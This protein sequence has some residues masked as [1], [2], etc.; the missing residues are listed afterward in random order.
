MSKKIISRVMCMILAVMMIL[1]ACSV[2]ESYAAGFLKAYTISSSN[3][4]VY[5][6][7]Y[8]QTKYGTIYPTDEL[9]ISEITASYLKVTYPAGTKTKTGY[10]PTNKV[11]LATSGYA[12]KVT[13]KITTY[14]RNSTGKTYGYIS[15]GDSVIELGTRGD[16][17]QVYYPVSGGNKIGW[18]R[19]SDATWKSSS[20]Q[21]PVSDGYYMIQSGNS[22][23]R[24]LDINNWTM[25]NCG[26]LEIYQKN[27]TT[28]QIFKITYVGNGYYKIMAYHSGKFLDVNNAS[29]ASGTNVQQYEWNGSA[30]QLWKFISAGNGYYYIQSKCGTYLDNSGG[31]TSNGNNVWAY[32]FNGSSAQKWKFLSVS[33]PSASTYY[34]TTAAGLIL[35]SD[36][37]TGSSKKTTIPYR[38]AVTVYENNGTWCYASY[39]GK[40]GY[41]SSRYL[42]KTIPSVSDNNS[43]S[44]YRIN[45]IGI[46]YNAGS[47]FTDN[48]KVCTDH[49]VKGKHSYY[50]EKACNCICTYNGKSLGAVQCFGFAR[51]VQTKLYGTNSYSSPGKFYKLSNAYV[52][53]GRLTASKLKSIIT[54]AKVGAHLRTNGSAHSMII[55]GIT[56]SGFSIIQCNGSNNKEYSGY[57]AC[58]IGTYTYTWNSYVNSTYGKRGIN[59]IEMAY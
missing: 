1:P 54:R 25:S 55:T 8:F 36:A 49:N 33:A 6:D 50:N 20:N 2:Q 45:G 23:S 48:G 52:S 21:R 17:I 37:S 51:Y 10:I 46:G 39:N 27:G 43:G 31:S 15:S 38:A 58:R 18:I 9:R 3:T 59:Y 11:L 47:Y 56:D 42:S 14:R 41:A 30:A 19:S 26:N 40:T 4:I 12:R 7:K 34:V 5:K 16:F 57:Y 22:T 24:V 29:G 44:G 32:S 35:R 28:N 13:K 53:S